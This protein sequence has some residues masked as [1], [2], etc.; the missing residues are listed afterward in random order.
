MNLLKDDIRKLFYRYLIPAISSAIAVAVYSF[1]DTIAIGQSAGP[2]GAAACAILLPVFSIAC[3]TG[4][5]CGVGGSVLMSQARGGG[6]N[7]KGDAYYTASVL[8]LSI[9]TVIIWILGIIFQEQFYR[10][11]GADDSL[12]PYSIEYGSWIFYFFPSFVLVSFLG[13]FI[14]TDGF[15]KF[16]MVSTIVG[17]VI[18]II[19]DWL[20]VFPLNMGMTGAAIAT[21]LGSAVQTVLLLGFILC[22]KTSL[23][24]AKPNRWMPAL[25][26]ISKVGF[27]AGFSQIAVI[28]VSFIVNN[29]IMKYSGSA[30][31]AVYGV[32]GTV[33]A[34]FMSIFSGV[35]Q[36]A[37]PI[38]SA[39][40][41]SG[42]HERYWSVQKL[43]IKTAIVSGVV[44]MAVCFIFPSQITEIFIK[45]TPE[46]A[47]IAP[48]I[49]RVYSIS[50]VPLAIN[51]FSTLY[52]QSVTHE[53][54][55]SVISLMRGIIL[56][57]ILLYLLPVVMKGNGIWWAITI[58][59]GITALMAV[60]YLLHIYRE[61][62]KNG[63]IRI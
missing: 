42:Q 56:N 50:F 17:G 62:K 37:Q 44:C 40:F 58:A 6:N 36:A 8:Y 18:N 2:D 23:K 4:L 28:A 16:V 31:L 51:T 30:A 39:N 60:I 21:V 13:C 26:N 38:V 33:A 59:E 57:G 61:Y 1:I 49:L 54:A 3:F 5:I 24:F 29:Q 34:L 9:I 48:Y 45:V 15:P 63:E 55:A 19:G 12:M 35:G 11:C 46:V 53:R 7:E 22:G 43:G 14:R 32:L 52:L 25:K 41:G 47:E 20:F 27:G 10:L